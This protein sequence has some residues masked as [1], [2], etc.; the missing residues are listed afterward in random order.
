MCRKIS[1]LALVLI[2]LTAPAAFAAEPPTSSDGLLGWLWNTVA[3]WVI[4]P[5]EAQE[6]GPV[7]DPYGLEDNTG[8][9]GPR[10]DPR[11]FDGQA[12]DDADRG[13]VV[14]PLG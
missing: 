5:S 13:P 2:L 11:G 4:G 9:A 10:V 14:D 12:E 1:N 8:E 6:N 7:V 3:E